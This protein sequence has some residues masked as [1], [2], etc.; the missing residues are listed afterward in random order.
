MTL[1]GFG[2]FVFTPRECT[3]LIKNAYGFWVV[4]IYIIPPPSLSFSPKDFWT[5]GGRKLT[6]VNPLSFGNVYDWRN[7]WKFN[8]SVCCHLAFKRSRNVISAC[9]GEGV[10]MCSLA[11][12][13]QWDTRI[14]IFETTAWAGSNFMALLT[15]SRESALTEAGITL[16]TASVFHGLAVNLGFCACVLHVTRPS[17]LTWLAKKFGACT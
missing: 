4:I 10:S 15:V 11:F 12:L 2:E 9:H 7:Q 8:C 6:Q 3:Y 14:I 17:T 5:I 16:L 1:L 13:F